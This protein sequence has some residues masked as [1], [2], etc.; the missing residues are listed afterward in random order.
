MDFDFSM[1]ADRTLTPR[2]RRV[3]DQLAREYAEQIRCTRDVVGV[4]PSRGSVA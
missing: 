3:Q 2:E 1:I 4:R